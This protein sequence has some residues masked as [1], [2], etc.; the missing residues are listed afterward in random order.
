MCLF[1]NKFKAFM[2]ERHQEFNDKII[3]VR[4]QEDK[5]INILDNNN[6]KNPQNIGNIKASSIS[7]KFIYTRYTSYH[8]KCI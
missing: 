3:V 4:D 6:Y 8:P 1:K 7:I 5:I 2:L